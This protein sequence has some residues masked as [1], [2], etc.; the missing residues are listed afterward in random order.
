MISTI[1]TLLRSVRWIV[2]GEFNITLMLEEKTEGT[3]RLDQDSGK[4]I[5]LIDQLKIIDIE[6]KNGFFTW[7]NWRSRPKHVARRLDCFLIS[8][9]IMLDDLVFEANILP[10]SGSYHWSVSLWLDTRATPKIKPFRFKK[11]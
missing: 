2:G 11:F 3:K 7:S 6:T 10:K 5:S 4:F 9:S 8:E 1:C